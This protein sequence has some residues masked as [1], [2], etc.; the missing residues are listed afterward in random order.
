V[1]SRQKVYREHECRS[2]QK[3]MQAQHA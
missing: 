1:L 3:M 2:L